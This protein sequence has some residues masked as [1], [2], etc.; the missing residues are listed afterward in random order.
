MTEPR[1]AAHA[2]PLSLTCPPDDRFADA[3]RA[4]VGR[5]GELA[6]VPGDAQPFTSAVEDVLTW[7]LAHPDAVNGDVSIVF[8]REGDR[9]CGQLQWVAANGSPELPDAGRPSSAHVQVDCD[10]DGP[11]VRC[12]V[13]CLCAC[14]TEYP[15][16]GPRH[17]PPE[18]GTRNPVPPHQPCASTTPSLARK[19]SSRHRATMSSACTPA[20]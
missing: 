14:R 16:P 5:V 6:G 11:E 12:R 10:T 1:E 18:P 2:L 9:L 20:G 17:R 7:L 13:S 15:V 3:V 19:K 4:L 8:D